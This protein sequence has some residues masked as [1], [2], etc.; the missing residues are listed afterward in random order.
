MSTLG[1]FNSCNLILL[2]IL[3]YTFTL[4]LMKALGWT[5]VSENFK[6]VLIMG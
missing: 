5:L 3:C 1:N 2:E 6:F 4:T